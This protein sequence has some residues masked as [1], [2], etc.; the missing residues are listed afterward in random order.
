MNIRIDILKVL[1]FL[2]LLMSCPKCT[3][4]TLVLI[5][6]FWLFRSDIKYLRLEYSAPQSLMKMY[7]LLQVIFIIAFISGIQSAMEGNFQ[8][9]GCLG[10]Y[11]M[12]FCQKL[13][14]LFDANQ[15]TDVSESVWFQFVGGESE[16]YT[17]TTFVSARPKC[18]RNARILEQSHSA[19]KMPENVH[20][21]K[22]QNNYHYLKWNP[23]T[24]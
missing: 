15:W 24:V 6:S 2:F 4:V 7:C 9:E 10:N 22:K 21:R 20:L 18:P 8:I 16:G 1:P 12:P 17:W 14:I 13:D 11:N 5:I 23:G 19:L 3:S